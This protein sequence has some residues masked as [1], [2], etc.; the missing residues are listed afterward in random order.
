M[1]EKLKNEIIQLWKKGM[2]DKDI[3]YELEIPERIVK[4]VL[5]KRKA[6]QENGLQK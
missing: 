5:S 2:D 1:D 6:D 3:A 4:Q